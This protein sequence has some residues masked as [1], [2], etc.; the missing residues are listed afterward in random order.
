MP[1]FMPE[2]CI[3]GYK[4]CK[5]LSLIESDPEVHGGELSFFCCG[6]NDGSERELEQDKYTVCFKNRSLDTE[7]HNDKRDLVHQMAVIAQALAI[8]E[9]D[10]SEEYHRK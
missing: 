5:P 7:S 6:E 3:R 8:I 2:K 10:D 4:T 1:I 9:E